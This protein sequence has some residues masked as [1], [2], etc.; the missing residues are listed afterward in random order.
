MSAEFLAKFF[1][2]RAVKEFFLISV[3]WV[4][5]TG[6]DANILWLISRKVFGCIGVKETGGPFFKRPVIG[7]PVLN[8]PKALGFKPEIPF[9][10]KR[11]EF[12]I[13]AQG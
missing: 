10:L 8:L 4:R 9:A 3:K 2:S 6:Y 12:P 1:K 5:E 13:C 7:L 11:F